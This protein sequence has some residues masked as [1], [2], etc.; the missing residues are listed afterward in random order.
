MVN[1]SETILATGLRL[2]TMLRS[3]D[4]FAPSFDLGTTCWPD[5]AAQ[6]ACYAFGRLF[7]FFG[8]QAAIASI[9]SETPSTAVA[10]LLYVIGRLVLECCY[11]TR[12]S[13]SVHHAN[14]EN[15]VGSRCV[16]GAG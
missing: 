2:L 13:S 14:A 16:S 15:V 3:V 1:K 5:E 4:F 12:G 9:T 7:S 6:P 10:E 11:K 8:G